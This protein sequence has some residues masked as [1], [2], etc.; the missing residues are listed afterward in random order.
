M[1]A[2]FNVYKTMGNGF[3][4]SV[5]QE[6]LEIELQEQQIPFESQQK[7]SLTYHGKTL[8]HSFVPDLICYEKIIIEIK[9]VSNITS[10]HRSQVHNYLHATNLKLAILVNF[11][12][13]EKLEYERIVN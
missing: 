2:C 6:C 11:G 5:Y 9:A 12:H 13:S 8:K 1:K 7:L 10:E 4:E 3:T